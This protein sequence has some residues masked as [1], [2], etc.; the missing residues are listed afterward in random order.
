M[1]WKVLELLK[2]IVFKLNICYCILIMNKY[3]YIRISHCPLNKFNQNKKTTTKRANLF[4][5]NEK[6]ITNG[7]KFFW[8]TRNRKHLFEPNKI[9]P[10]SKAPNKNSH[11]EALK[12][13]QI[14]PPKWITTLLTAKHQP[15]T[16]HSQ[17]SLNQPH[18][19]VVVHSFK[20]HKPW[21][22]HFAVNNCNFAFPRAIAKTNI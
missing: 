20:N 1:D 7:K 13:K 21:S 2:L 11:P 19:V 14:S 6:C 15:T 22:I 12:C 18:R 17:Q 4:S 3:I 9:L 10:N 8:I 5:I 16:H